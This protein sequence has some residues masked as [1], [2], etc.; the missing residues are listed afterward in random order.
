MSV[1][2]A[3]CPFRKDGWTDLRGLLGERALNE[4]APVCHSTGS[5]ALVPR[6]KRASSRMKL[7]RGAR[8]LQLTVFHRLGVIG[9]PTD[10][11]WDAKA[12]ELGL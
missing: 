2:C 6:S 10:E 7:C 3:T 9:A 11:A 8:D 4:G 1:K 12:K 5:K